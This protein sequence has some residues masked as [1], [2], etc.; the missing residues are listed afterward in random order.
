MKFSK[1]GD[2]IDNKQII[3]GVLQKIKCANGKECD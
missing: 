2:Q 1:A 3:L